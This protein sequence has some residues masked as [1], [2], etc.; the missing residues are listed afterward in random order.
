MNKTQH[1]HCERSFGTNVLVLGKR[2]DNFLSPLNSQKR[3]QQKMSLQNKFQTNQLCSRTQLCHSVT[4]ALT[5]TAA[6]GWI[7]RY[8]HYQTKRTF[9]SKIR[10][11]C[12]SYISTPKKPLSHESTFQFRL[13][14]VSFTIFGIYIFGYHRMYIY[15]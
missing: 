8:R 13:W 5:E 2:R 9:V 14:D 4:I 1:R 6:S 10:G 12:D 3:R 15:M 11:P 7:S